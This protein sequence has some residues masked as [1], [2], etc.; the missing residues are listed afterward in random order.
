MSN[1]ACGSQRYPCTNPHT[2]TARTPCMPPK[3]TSRLARQLQL[4]ILAAL[5]REPT[6]AQHATTQVIGRRTTWCIM[7]SCCSPHVIDAPWHTCI[8][9]FDEFLYEILH[10]H[11]CF[12]DGCRLYSPKPGGS[13]VHAY[14]PLTGAR[15][16]NGIA[17][18]AR[19]RCR[20]PLQVPP[21]TPLSLTSHH[22]PSPLPHH[23]SHSHT[24]IRHPPKPGIRPGWHAQAALQCSTYMTHL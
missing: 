14:A 13:A 20:R 17:G 21:Y 5:W 6:H 10:T 7:H 2:S 3:S 12:T 11:L 8:P 15:K 18:A 22:S 23:T 24:A 16:A 19:S 9:I 1:V 4:S